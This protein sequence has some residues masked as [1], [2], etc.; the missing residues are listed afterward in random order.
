MC[1]TSLLNETFSFSSASTGSLLKPS[2]F[3]LLQ[4]LRCIISTAFVGRWNISSING[5]GYAMGRDPYLK[6]VRF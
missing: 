1:L 6:K 4:P 2:A 5:M 3:W